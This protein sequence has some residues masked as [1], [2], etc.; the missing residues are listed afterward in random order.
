MWGTQFLDG[1]LDGQLDLVVASGHLNDFRYLGLPYR[2]RPQYF[3]NLGDGRFVEAPADTL[4]E[5]Y[6][7]EHL[8][9]AVARLDWNRDGLE[10]H[11]TTHV[12]S[13]VAL[14][15][16]VTAEHG[17]YLAV[18]LVGTPS[19]RDAIGTTLRLRAGKRTW[20]RQLTA[21]DGFYASNERKLILGLGAET[22]VEELMVLWPSGRDQ[23]FRNLEADRE[24][25][26]VEGSA[27]PMR[28]PP[29]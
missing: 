9:R 27:V 18:R 11:C 17:H 12:E 6:Q 16:N 25:V 28:L 10:D 19:S 1:E 4:G 15:T 8:G 13:P 3:Q 2:M 20:T 5:Y 29:P 22:V 21:G 14:L 7:H 24:V 26:L 23:T